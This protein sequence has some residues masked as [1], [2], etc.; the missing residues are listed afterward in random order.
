MYFNFKYHGLSLIAVGSTFTLHGYFIFDLFIAKKLPNKINGVE[1]H[2]HNINNFKISD[3]FKPTVDD[4]NEKIILTII[5]IINE[6][7]GKKRAVTI[8]FFNHSFPLLFLYTV[9]LIKPQKNS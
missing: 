6:I 3:I 5:K 7:P 8:V 2:I 4:S 9:V 1:T